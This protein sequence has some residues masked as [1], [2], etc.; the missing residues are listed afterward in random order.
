MQRWAQRSRNLVLLGVLLAGIVGIASVVTTLWGGKGVSEVSRPVEM[1]GSLQEQVDAGK[2]EVMPP[3]SIPKSEG[4]TVRARV[5][6]RER[7]V[8]VF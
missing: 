8:D 2:K 6:D 1:S 3:D 7:W 4:E 5:K